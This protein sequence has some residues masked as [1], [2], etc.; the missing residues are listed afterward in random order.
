MN[1][2]LKRSDRPARGVGALATA[3]VEFGKLFGGQ[4]GVRAISKNRSKELRRPFKFSCQPI[5]ARVDH[6]CAN[7]R[8]PAVL[9][10]GALLAPTARRNDI[11][12]HAAYRLYG[13]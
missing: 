5:G 12:R 10:K 1:G 9:L 11:E 4:D 7:I 2:P 13:R 3:V 8:L 6:R